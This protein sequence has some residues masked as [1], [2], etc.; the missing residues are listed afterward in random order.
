[1][2]IEYRSYF[3]PDLMQSLLD[4]ILNSCEV[5]LNFEFTFIL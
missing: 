5:G 1:M 2:F 3:G 4:I